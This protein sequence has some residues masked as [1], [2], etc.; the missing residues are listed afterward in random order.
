MW[1]DITRGMAALKSVR[2]LGS[3]AETAQTVPTASPTLPSQ[4]L[5]E[6]ETY[7]NLGRHQS[8]AILAGDTLQETLR[9]L[10]ADFCI[11]LPAKPAIVQMNAQL[12]RVGVY[13]S[14]ME[15]RIAEWNSLWDKAT[16]GLW[17]EFSKSD[18]ETMLG[19]LREFVTEHTVN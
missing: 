8:A 12:A 11:A 14:L 1:I 9:K 13:D 10:C 4:F 5:A 19:D 15:Q 7:L 17:S 16:C 2:S 3:T 18:V 6:A